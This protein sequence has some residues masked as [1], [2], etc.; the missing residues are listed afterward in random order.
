VRGGVAANGRESGIVA[1]GAK[2]RDG[3][4]GRVGDRL[5]VTVVAGGV[6]VTGQKNVSIAERA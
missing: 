1:V 2:R 6:G 3:V 4:N 5:R